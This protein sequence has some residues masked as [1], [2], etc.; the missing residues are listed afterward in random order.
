MDISIVI[1]N[2]DQE[3]KKLKIIPLQP[4]LFDYSNILETI[5]FLN[6]L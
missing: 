4:Y 3:L 1:R 5:F 2:Y 6:F